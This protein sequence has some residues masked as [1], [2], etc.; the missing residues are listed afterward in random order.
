MYYIQY[1]FIVTAIFQYSNNSDEYC[2]TLQHSKSAL[3]NLKYR[4]V[5]HNV[6]DAG[7]YLYRYSAWWDPTCSTFPIFTRDAILRKNIAQSTRL[8]SSRY[9][10]HAANFPLSE[11]AA[12]WK[13]SRSRFSLKMKSCE[14]KGKVWER[15]K[16]HSTSSFTLHLAR[17]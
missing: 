10:F 1:K 15:D 7:I 17:T 3:R 4:T 13:P 12:R 11:S 8:P 6:N 9:I 5:K 16:W 2:N 14:G